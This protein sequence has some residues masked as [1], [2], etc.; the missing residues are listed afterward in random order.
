MT[1]RTT[2]IQEG[3]SHS[4]FLVTANKI[5]GLRK[6]FKLALEHVVQSFGRMKG[7]EDVDFQTKSSYE[8]L[9][10]WKHCQL[11]PENKA[12][13]DPLKPRVSID[14]LMSVCKTRVTPY[15]FRFRSSGNK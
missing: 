11:D 14:V 3:H 15:T 5:W 8:N 7:I 2:T 9:K 12:M 4:Q 6:E 10:I 1:M 13:E